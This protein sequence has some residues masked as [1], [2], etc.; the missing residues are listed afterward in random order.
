MNNQKS[1]LQTYK[2]T[3]LKND[4]HKLI[5]YLKCQKIII[6]YYVRLN[7]LTSAVSLFYVMVLYFAGV[8]SDKGIFAWHLQFCAQ[9][10][11]TFIV[12]VSNVL[13]ANVSERQKKKESLVFMPF[14]A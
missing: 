14:L 3:Y 9:E 12:S 4:S 5:F 11:Q 10:I 13:P 1:W 7:I 8:N 2:I 6:Q